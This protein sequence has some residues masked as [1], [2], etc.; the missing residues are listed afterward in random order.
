MKKLIIMTGPQGSGNHLFSKM[1]ASNPHVGGWGNLNE[2]FWE[3]HH[4]EPFY[5]VWR[6]DR[7]LAI[8]DFDGSD[9]WVTSVS[10]PVLVKGGNFNVDIIDFYNQAKELGIDVQLGII[11]RDKNILEHQQTRVREQSTIHNFMEMLDKVDA[12]EIPYHMF[13][14]ESLILHGSRYASYIMNLVGYP[15]EFDKDIIKQIVEHNSNKKYMKY[16]DE[17]WLDEEIVKA[18]KESI[19]A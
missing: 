10:I 17:Y 13:S 3:G 19:D 14:H 8:E 9:Y 18:K 12:E 6:G 1:F 4:L 16:V 5:Y 2:T 11:T 15:N 7:K